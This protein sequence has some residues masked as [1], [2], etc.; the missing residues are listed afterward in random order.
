MRKLWVLFCFSSLVSSCYNPGATP[1]PVS[2]YKPVLINKKDL[3]NSVMLLP[4]SVPNNPGKYLLNGNHL[5]M[6]ELYKGVHVFD[7]SHPSTPINSGFI[8]VPGIQT[9]SI[10]NNVLYVD[11]A[12]DIVA[13]D[14]TNPTGAKVLSRIADV[15]PMP[16]TPDGLPLD[17]PV[18]Q[19]TWPAN[20]V[21][22]D[23][24]K[25]KN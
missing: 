8:N 20:T 9:I 5:Y 17:G 21:V 24:V 22:V 23:Y 16:V 3:V 15:L 13:I 1:K 14:I 7:N 11:N 25:L 2:A 4:A 18:A 6:V 19:S 12:I 10:K